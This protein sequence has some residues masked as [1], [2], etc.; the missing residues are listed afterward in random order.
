MQPLGLV[1]FL[2][3]T[4]RRGVSSLFELVLGKLIF[5]Q[6]SLEEMMGRGWLETIAA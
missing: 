5:K 3:I 2:K 1:V 4:Q 6:Q